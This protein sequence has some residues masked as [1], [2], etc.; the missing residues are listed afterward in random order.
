M[1]LG[2]RRTACLASL[3]SYVTVTAVQQQIVILFIIIVIIIIIIN[4]DIYL[5]IRFH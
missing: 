2:A 5:I 3:Y 1:Q 4:S